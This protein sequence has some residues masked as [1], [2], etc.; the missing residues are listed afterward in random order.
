MPV[1]PNIV[2]S[3]KEYFVNNIAFRMNPDFDFK[4][5]H[6]M[7]VE[8]IYA[9]NVVAVDDDTARVELSIIIRETDTPLPFTLD[10]T[11]AITIGSAGWQTTPA[12]RAFVAN[13]GITILYPYLRSLVTS[14]TGNMN[15]V[16]YTPP[17]MNIV[18]YIAEQEKKTVSA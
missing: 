3:V 8:P 2:F 10:A 1:N 5:P 17:F 6:K 7:T 14:V 11:I 13:T 18:A 4:T 15:Y 16:P 9:R 12:R